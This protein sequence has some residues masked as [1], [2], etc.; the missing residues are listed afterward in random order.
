MQS[1]D[2]NL[3]VMNLLTIADLLK[4]LIQSCLALF[5]HDFLLFPYEFDDRVWFEQEKQHVHKQ[6]G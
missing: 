2:V 6:L 4:L 5:D 3:Q 1:T